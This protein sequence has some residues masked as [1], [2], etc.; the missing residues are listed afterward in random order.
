MDFNLTLFAVEYK[1]LRIRH[2]FLYEIYIYIY[3]Y[4]PVVL[5][6]SPLLFAVLESRDLVLL[7]KG[8]YKDI[9]TFTIRAAWPCTYRVS[10]DAVKLV[11]YQCFEKNNF[12]VFLFNFIHCRS[13]VRGDF[14]ADFGD[15]FSAFNIRL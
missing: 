15:I 7:L 14:S 10:P 8:T 11:M 13:F 6:I 4:I 3:I 5:K 9:F 2:N 1:K 12:S